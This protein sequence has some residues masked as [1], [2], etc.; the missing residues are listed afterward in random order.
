[1]VMLENEPN[2]KEILFK[3]KNL[4]DGHGIEFVLAYGTLL[5]ACRNGRLLPWDVDLDVIVPFKSYEDF[6]NADLFGLLRDAYKKGF[7]F[8]S[9]NDDFIADNEH[10]KYPEISLLPKERQWEEYLKINSEWKK[11]FKFMVHW[12]SISDYIRID[13]LVTVKGIHPTYVYDEPLGKVVLY[14]EIFNIPPNHLQ[15]LSDYYGKN[16]QDVF[17]SYKLWM[18]NIAALREG[19]VPQEIYDFMMKWKPLLEDKGDQ[20]H[21]DIYNMENMDKLIENFEKRKFEMGLYHHG[22]QINEQKE[23]YERLS[24]MIDISAYPLLKLVCWIAPFKNSVPNI[25]TLMKYARSSRI[26]IL[27]IGTCHGASAV[28]IG[29]G[30]KMYGGNNP[31]LITIDIVQLES[32]VKGYFEL[33]KEFLPSN[34]YIIQSDSKAFS[35]NEPI[36]LLYIDGGHEYED[37]YEDCKKYIP[38]VIKGGICIFHDADTADVSRAITKFFDDNKDKI[39]FDRFQDEPIN[40]DSSFQYNNVGILVIR[41]LE[42]LL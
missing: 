2:L 7:R 25:F 29:I 33:F 28:A 32:A 21:K 15:Y 31:K 23:S 26:C 17:C 5:G 1:M 30:A 39:K 40:R 18:N 41:I 14:G 24:K 27:E 12:Y 11:I 34:R 3:F 37:V 20:I 13:C 6:V 35:F 42:N 10:F 9:W 19:H 38:L 8:V 36:D 4:M 22:G 16:W